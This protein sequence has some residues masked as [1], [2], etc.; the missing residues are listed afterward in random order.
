MEV[1]NCGA[2]SVLTLALGL[3]ALGMSSGRPAAAQRS[4]AQEDLA[5]IVQGMPDREH[6]LHSPDAAE[7]KKAREELQQFK[8][9]LEAWAKDNGIQLDHHVEVGPVALFPDCHSYKHLDG[10]TW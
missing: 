7:A 10:H 3:T 8:R 6:R 9:H 1:Q 4:S 5:R 2:L